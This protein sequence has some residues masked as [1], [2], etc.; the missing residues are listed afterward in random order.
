MSGGSNEASSSSGSSFESEIPLY[1][2]EKLDLEDNK[3]FRVVVEDE[4]WTS[5]MFS[6]TSVVLVCQAVDSSILK[7]AKKKQRGHLCGSVV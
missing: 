7:T 2:G 3:K 5:Q 4:S 1:N 6:S